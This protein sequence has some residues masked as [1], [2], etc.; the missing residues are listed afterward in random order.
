MD[1]YILCEK[2]RDFRKYSLISWMGRRKIYKYKYYSYTEI[3]LRLCNFAKFPF[4]NNFFNVTKDGN[5]WSW[6][7][8]SE[9][10]RKTW[11]WREKDRRWQR[12]F[13]NR[14]NI[15]TGKVS[16]LVWYNRTLWW[17]KNICFKRNDRGSSLLVLS[18]FS[19]LFLIFLFY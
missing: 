15:S 8:L 4:W 1:R 19:F 5:H 10:F 11:P 17:Y 13:D 9:V 12:T 3:D 14:V 16:I 7:L 2:K 18:S 6:A